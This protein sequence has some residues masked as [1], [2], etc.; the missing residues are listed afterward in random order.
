[1]ATT[2]GRREQP[3]VASR[4]AQ[5]LR[6][7]WRPLSRNH[8]ML[9]GVVFL[10]MVSSLAVLAP[11]IART[12]PTRTNTI[13]RL[14]SPSTRH[15]FGT[16][17]LGMDVFDRT[18]YGGRVSLFVGITVA[19]SVAAIGVTVGLVAGYY[20]RLDDLIMRL[21]DAMMA[22]PTLMLAL[23]MIS[24]LGG[25]V[26]NVII[27]IVAVDTPRMVRLV[28]GQVLSLREQQFVEAAKAVGASV[29]RTLFVHI[30]PNTFGVVMVAATLYF[31]GAVM[32]EAALSYLGAGVAPYTPTWGNIMSG[33][34]RYLQ[35]A[36]WV[37]FFPG[38]FLFLTVLAI[39]LVGD[40]LRDA[41]DPR[42]RRRL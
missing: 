5:R 22:F 26:Q 39:N 8:Y 15:F 31:A 16:D 14:Q 2:I 24:V 38:L 10:V 1:V 25:S 21:A 42:L 28:R 12:E 20:R 19:L 37:S 27:V 13:E 32:T 4:A 41:L 34:Q 40:G 29:P 6:A 17:N 33:G 9:S 18:L 23:A 3:A 35:A 36:V 11:L 7:A 30:A